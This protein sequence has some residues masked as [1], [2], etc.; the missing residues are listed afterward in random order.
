MPLPLLWIGA[1]LVGAALT[2]D[3]YCDKAQELAD[4]DEFKRLNLQ[5]IDSFDDDE[6]E[7]A[8]VAKFPSDVLTSQVTAQPVAGAIVCCGVFGAFDHT[9]IWVDD[10]LIVELHGCG[11]IKAVS[12][13]RF[14]RHRSG[15]SLFV[16]CDSNAQPLVVDGS[17]ERAAEQVFNF[18]LY[19]VRDNNC[20]RFVWQ[21]VNE[22]TER[23]ADF[24]EFNHLLAKKHHK[25]VYWDKVDSNQ[26]FAPSY[27]A[28]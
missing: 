17:A 4:E 28:S 24:S 13:E 19:Q 12:V 26:L 14:L 27:L 1:G 15:S 22:H 8:A 16:A 21:C 7:E 18:W 5:S 20:H 23:V 25:K 10:N 3:H 9:G 6:S 11:L 2:A